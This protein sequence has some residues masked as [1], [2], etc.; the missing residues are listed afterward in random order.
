MTFL[1]DFVQA[2]NEAGGDPD[3][4]DGLEGWLNFYI[5][6]NELTISFQPWKE[7]TGGP[8]SPIEKR[9]RLTEVND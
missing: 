4:N 9:W 5:A 3:F 7:E 1:F 8:G 6:G 2:L